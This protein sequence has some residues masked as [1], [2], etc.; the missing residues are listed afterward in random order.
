MR[1]AGGNEKLRV[2]E[3]K[4]FSCVTTRF[5][6]NQIGSEGR[7]GNFHKSKKGKKETVIPAELKSVLCFISPSVSYSYD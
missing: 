7:G 1:P 3:K 5:V 6:K 4:K 2:N